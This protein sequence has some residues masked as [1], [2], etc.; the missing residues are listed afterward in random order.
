MV[1]ITAKGVDD[2][3]GRLQEA[4][5]TTSF[6]FNAPV[7]S[8]VIGTHNTAELINNF[9]FSSIEARIEREGDADAE[10]PR[11]AL[12]EASQRTPVMERRPL[13]SEEA[14]ELGCIL[15]CGFR[16]GFPGGRAKAHTW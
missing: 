11:E 3:G 16:E 8:S 14:Q 12:A 1:N 13:S 5:P 2:V 4:A 7:H 10:E 9:D 6:I 15:R